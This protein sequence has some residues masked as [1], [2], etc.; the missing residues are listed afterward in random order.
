M[1]LDY[2]SE[3]ASYSTVPASVG[4]AQ[5]GT[6]IDLSAGT[7]VQTV[8][9]I[10]EDASRQLH[11]QITIKAAFTSAG[12]ATVSFAVRTDAADP[13]TSGPVVVSTGAIPV[14]DLTVGT[15]LYLAVPMGVTE[16]YIGLTATVGAFDLTAGAVSSG[17]MYDAH[18]N[19]SYP[20]AVN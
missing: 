14:A 17:I 13:V 10:G 11:I 15:Q 3:F 8:S 2:L 18:G 7:P 19:Y 20:D 12:A 5:V 4:T 16:R 1:I 6:S 9:R